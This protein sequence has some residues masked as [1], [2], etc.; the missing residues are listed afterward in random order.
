MPS[1]AAQVMHTHT[2]A[3]THTC[4]HAPRA[5]I[6]THAPA[7]THIHLHAKIR[8]SSKKFTH[9]QLILAADRRGWKFMVQNKER[10]LWWPGRKW[11]HHKEDRPLISTE[12][13]NPKSTFLLVLILLLCV[14]VCGCHCVLSP[15]TFHSLQIAHS[16]D[17][18]ESLCTLFKG[19]IGQNYPTVANCYRFL[20]SPKAFLSLC[21]C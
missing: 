4:T 21:R 7:C 17:H 19:R 15:Q 16:K 14:G 5:S 10:S 1:P 2:H 18:F 8:L 6:H 20:Y 11:I 12:L 3:R 9:K 13:W